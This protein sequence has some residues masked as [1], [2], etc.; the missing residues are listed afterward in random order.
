MPAYIVTSADPPA[1]KAGMTRL[2][3]SGWCCAAGGVTAAVGAVITARVH[4][5]VPSTQESYPWTPGAAQALQLLWTVCSALIL[6]G[7]IA[8][9]RSGLSG[10][11]RLARIGVAI[12][13]VA[14]ALLVPA[15]A[16]FIFAEHATTSSTASSVLAAVAT[17]VAVISGVGFTLTG[18]AT[19]HTGR[20]RGPGRFLPLVCGLFVLVVLFPVIAVDPDVFFWPIAGWNFCLAAFG[21]AL[22]DAGRRETAAP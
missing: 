3:R 13:V 20:W 16:S 8:F 17:S 4:A 1:A 12:T 19:L 7:L 14:M 10:D 9:A 11:S 22:V 21:L 15:Q 6:V 5:S 2:S 18:I